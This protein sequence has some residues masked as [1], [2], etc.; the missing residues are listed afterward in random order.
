MTVYEQVR[1]RDHHLCRICVRTSPPLEVH[2]IIFRS[3]GG[4][5][6]LDNLILLCKEHH[7]DAHGSARPGTQ[8][9][10]WWLQ[11]MLDFGLSGN[12]MTERMMR[13]YPSC[14]TCE[15]RRGDWTCRVW[16]N[17]DCHPHYGCNAWKLRT[18]R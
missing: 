9:A 5:D 8:I 4:S 17:Q 13:A 18:G 7:M 3:Q 14:R 2:H 12:R 6:T 11:F 15:Y 16:D 1:E 10:A